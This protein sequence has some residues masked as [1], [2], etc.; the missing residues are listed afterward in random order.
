ML[1]G[2]GCNDDDDDSCFKTIIPQLW[3]FLEG[4]A[5]QWAFFS[6]CLLPY[7]SPLLHKIKRGS[8]NSGGNRQHILTSFFTRITTLPPPQPDSGGGRSVC[9][10][11]GADCSG[12][13]GR[14]L[15]GLWGE[16]S[17]CLV[18]ACFSLMIVVFS[19]VK[20]FMYN[21]YY[22]NCLYFQLIWALFL[23]CYFLLFL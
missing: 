23:S 18:I 13:D 16:L 21:L 4:M 1:R 11:W 2:L 14:V 17:C 15:L 6:L 3:H 7:S 5:L 19:Y 22:F 12:E 8:V 10:R 20:L 9:C